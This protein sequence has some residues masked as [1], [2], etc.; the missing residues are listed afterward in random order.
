[1]QEFRDR[2][3]SILGVN[4]SAE[5]LSMIDCAIRD[6]GK[7]FKIE[8]KEET[9]PAIRRQ[10][11]EQEIVEYLNRKKLKGCAG[12]TIGQYRQALLAFNAVTQK[13][14][15]EVVDTDIIEF[16]EKYEAYRNIGKARKDDLR[17]IL[18]G[19][20]RYMSDCG[21]ISRNPMVTIDKIKVPVRLRYPL[22]RTEL[23]RVRRACRTARDLALVDFMFSTGCRVSEVVSVNRSD[24]DY[25]NMSIRVIGKG[26][27][28]RYVFLNTDAVVLLSEYFGERE[29][30]NDALFVSNRRPHGRLKK[31]AIEKIVR[32]LGV[33]A[34]LPRRLFPHIFRHTMATYLY[35][36]GMRI[37]D[38]QVIL[39]HTSA[40]TTQI[41]ARQ[42][43]RLVQQ[44]YF[45]IAA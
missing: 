4:F 17:R 30:K 38:L 11:S 26:N 18:N 22:S 36:H 27:K 31:T 6:A 35:N 25:A 42:D 1:M 45:R 14:I 24:I 33:Q 3:L 19:F 29:D 13:H 23:T 39:G 44:A 32:E 2:I 40:E 12:S 37:E 41:Y 20:F 16:L 7:D 10:G 9:L 8:R 43:P 5:Q 28:E 21:R 15:Q 34:K